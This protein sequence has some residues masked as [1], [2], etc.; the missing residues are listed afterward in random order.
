MVYEINRRVEVHERQTYWV[1]RIRHSIEG[2]QVEGEL[3]HDKIVGIVCLFDYTTQALLIRCAER[4][5]LNKVY[6][7]KRTELT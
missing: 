4:C 7:E 1:T 6:Q 2:S 5:G 3:I